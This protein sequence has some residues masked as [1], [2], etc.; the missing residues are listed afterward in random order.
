MKRIMSVM[1]K[2]LLI[3]LIGGGVLATSLQA[4][5]EHTVTV[6]IPFQFT[7]GRQSIAPGIYRISLSPSTFEMSIV[8]AKS[9]HAEMFAVLPEQERALERGGRVVFQKREDRRV[10]NEVHFPGTDIF[11]QVIQPHGVERF[12]AK[13]SAPSDSVSVAQR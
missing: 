6:R 13:R 11:I 9:G 3:V 5:S 10:L 12:M 1:M 7:V 2:S 8:D 4:Q